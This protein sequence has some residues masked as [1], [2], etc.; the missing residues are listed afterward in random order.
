MKRMVLIKTSLKSFFKVSYPKKKAKYS[1]NLSGI[2][3]YVQIFT[4][5]RWS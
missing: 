5:M 4:G 1:R 3:D 2:E